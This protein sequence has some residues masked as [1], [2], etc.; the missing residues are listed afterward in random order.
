MHPRGDGELELGTG[1][2]SLMATGTCQGQWGPSKSP[3]AFMLEAGW[4]WM[5]GQQIWSKE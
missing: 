1:N 3:L 4:G 5:D 2:R